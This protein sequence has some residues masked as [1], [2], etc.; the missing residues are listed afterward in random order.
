MATLSSFFRISQEQLE[1]LMVVLIVLTR[2]KEGH[3][4]VERKTDE[5]AHIN[6]MTVM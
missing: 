3:L 5:R 2:P 6:D 1:A 4:P